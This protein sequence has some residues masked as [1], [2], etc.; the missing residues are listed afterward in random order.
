[1]F[2]GIIEDRGRIVAMHTYG[3][4]VSFQ[5]ESSISHECYIDQSISHNGVCLTIEKIENNI[6]TVT[7]VEETLLKTTLGS[8]TIGSY[9]NL[10]RCMKLGDRLDGHIVQGH[11]D[12]VGKCIAKED[13]DGS[14]L[15]TF[16]YP[17]ANR[18][19]LVEKGSI[20]VNGVSLTAFNCTDNHFSVAIIPYTYTHTNFEELAPEDSINL[21]FDILGKYFAR[22]AESYAEARAK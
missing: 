16:E 11:V 21:E 2:S 7:A 17:A 1:M 6:H 19:L 20:A 8:W 12:T 18:H 5:I 3:T 13:K 15:F 4:N 22:W 9:I 10:E 14:W